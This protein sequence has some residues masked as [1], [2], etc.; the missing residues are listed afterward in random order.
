MFCM[1]GGPGVG[2]SSLMKK[3]AKEMLIEDMM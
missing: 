3:V 2:K 1:K